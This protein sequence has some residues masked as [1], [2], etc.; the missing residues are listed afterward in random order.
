MIAS[1]QHTNLDR[2]VN[3][4][5]AGFF[6]WVLTFALGYRNAEISPHLRIHPLDV[7]LWFLLVLLFLRR[8]YLHHQRIRLWLPRWVW[9]SIPFWILAWKSG[10]AA[11]QPWD[12]ML[13]EV[14]NIIA[15]IP[16]FLV[17]EAI[18]ITRRSWRILTLL[19]FVAGT[20]IAAIGVLEFFFPGIAHM[21][22]GYI[23]NPYS[24]LTAEGFARASFS[25]WGTS[26]A[27]FVCLLALP[28]GVVLW[29]QELMLRQRI[30]IIIAGGIQLTGI[31]IGGYRSVWLFVLLNA[32]ILVVFRAGPIT[33]GF[34]L[35]LSTML[36]LRESS[37]SNQRLYSLIVALGGHPIDSSAIK[38]WGRITNA[39]QNA[40]D[41]PLGQGWAVNGWVHS[42]FVQILANLGI[43]A[44]LLFLA[45]YG[46]VLIRLW[47][48]LRFAPTNFN[49]GL[50]MA[51]VSVGG[52]LASQGVQVLPQLFLPAMFVWVLVEIHLRTSSEMINEI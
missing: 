8:P 50:F 2:D 39:L 37:S 51:F 24:Q 29:K 3:I 35:F 12:K 7:L 26:A 9:L 36:Y 42:D 33:G 15:I 30:V 22:P 49:M 27:T 44:G 10:L 43:P 14:K 47:R 41:S 38:R 4:I 48:L 25:F 28:M 46:I 18:L 32:F 13:S 31:Y 45:A 20:L 5:R 34:S 19:F 16:L 52:I 6:L 40:L 23:S 11:G 1:R 17:S 21:F